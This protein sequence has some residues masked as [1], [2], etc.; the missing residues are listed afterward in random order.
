MEMHNQSSPPSSVD[1]T[2]ASA[3]V[4]NAAEGQNEKSSG[5]PDGGFKAW[6]VVVGG[7][8]N[9]CATFGTKLSNTNPTTLAFMPDF[10]V[11]IP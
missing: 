3:T 4:D 11:A 6:A 10:T 1:P 9:Y 2:G 7:L 8:I 5:A